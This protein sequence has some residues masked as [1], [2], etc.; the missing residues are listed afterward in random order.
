[1]EAKLTAES[2]KFWQAGKRQKQ[3]YAGDHF[4]TKVRDKEI[5]TDL[6]TKSLSGL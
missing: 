3:T 1:M 6:K 4:V 5:V 2:R